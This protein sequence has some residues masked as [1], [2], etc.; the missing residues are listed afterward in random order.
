MDSLLANYASS[1]EEEDQKPPSTEP[2]SSTPSRASSLFSSLPQPKSSALFSSLPQ[3][4]QPQK[5]P[6][7]TVPIGDADDVEEGLSEKGAKF[8]RVVDNREEE[9]EKGSNPTSLFSSLPQPKSQNPQQPD[10]S[11]GSSQS[12]PK[13]VVQFKPPIIPTPNK[14]EDDEDDED[15][16]EEERRR[17]RESESSRQGPS[18]TSFL[19]SIPAPKNSVTLGVLPSSGSGRRSIIETEVPASSSSSFKA[20][21]ESGTDHK[22]VNYASTNLNSENNVNYSNYES[23]IDQ[24]TGSSVDNA[25]YGNYESGFSQNVDYS[26]YGS[27]QPSA[28]Q[29][30]GSYDAASY[31]SYEGYVSNYGQSENNWVDGSA[32]MVPETIG[33]SDIGMQLPRKRGRNELPT[34]IV[35]V[36][37][38]ELMKN[39]PR[40]D[41]VKLTGIAF[42][43]SYQPASTKGKPSK[44]HKRKHQIGSLYF[45]MRQKETE[46]AERRAKGFLTKAE[47]QAKY[48]W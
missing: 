46:L 34:E 17:R 18:V 31:G 22:V 25:G 6:T 2:L 32:A 40:E 19:S 20:E 9:E 4:K 45:D 10:S 27:Y 42:G 38:D 11:L 43:P 12:N 23:S 24:N 35:E 41:Q 33:V 16:E 29:N 28:D 15:D 37:Q 48:G 1:D 7:T 47:T 21:N 5:I 8:S 36:K 14:F 44:L 13:R 39:R 30:V 26:G 3:P